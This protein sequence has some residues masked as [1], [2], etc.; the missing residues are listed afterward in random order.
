ML[1]LPRFTVSRSA[2]Q[3][4]LG[5]LFLTLALGCGSRSAQNNTV[6]KSPATAASTDHDGN[7]LK[8]G[9][10]KAFPHRFVLMPSEST[11]VD[12]EHRLSD[13][14]PEGRLYHTG[15]GCG[16]IAI[17]DI[18]GD[19]LPDLYF[20]NGPGPNRL[21]RNLGNLRFE[22]ITDAAGVDGGAT[23]S[24][25]V[26]M[27]DIDND[28]DLDLY[29]C[30]Y[31]S[32]NLL[33]IND[34]TGHFT[35]AASQW[36]LDHKDACLTATFHDYDCD[37]DLD[38]FL[39][40][41]RYYRK[42]GRPTS[43]PFVMQ[44]GKPAIKPGYAQYY[45]LNEKTPGKYSVDDYGRPNR[46][47]RNNGSSFEDI[48]EAAGI[49]GHGHTLSATWWDYNQDGWPDL[50]VC[51]DFNDPDRLYHNNGDGT[52]RDAL[53]EVVPHTPWFSMG[54]DAGDLNNDG[55]VDFFCVDMSA[56][57]HFGQKTTMGA[58]NA[59]RMA[60]VA[61]P[62]PQYM[63]NA[64]YMNTDAGRC[65]E[66]AYLAGLADSDWSWGAKLADLDNDGHMDV[67]VTNGSVRSFN[68]SDVP[69]ET[70]M[71]IGKTY[72]DLYRHLPERPEQ[73][74]VFANQ[75]DL[76]FKD[77]SQ[78]W[79]L[80]L[81]G[82]SYGAAWADLDQDNDLDL[83]VANINQPVSIYRNDV[84][85]NPGFTVRLQGETNNSFGL[86]ARVELETDKSRW[87]RY[88]NPMSGY[89][90]SNEP[91]VHFGVGDEQPRHLTV[92]WPSG[93]RQTVEVGDQRVVV[94]K[95]ADLRPISG[96]TET[97]T[98]FSQTNPLPYQHQESSFDDFE[99]Q[100]LLPNRL[101]Q[102]GPGIATAD[103]DADGDL[104]LYIG[105]S[106]RSP[107]SLMINDGQGTYRP[108]V[109]Q[110]FQDDSGYEDMGCLFF[111]ADGDDDQDLYVVSGSIESLDNMGLLIDRLYLNDGNLNF[112]RS[113][114]ST[115]PTSEFSG[116]AIS[117][118]DFDRDGDLD[119][120]I[121]GR[122]VPGRYPT[123]PGS[124]LYRNDAGRFT[125]V[126]RKHAEA[127]LNTGMVSGATWTDV[128]DDGWD[129][130]VIVGEWHPVRIF[131]NQQGTL[132]NQTV[133]SSLEQVSGWFNGVTARD[134]DGD[135]DIDL[136]VTNFGLNTKYHAS[137]AH[138]ALIYYGDFENNGR[139]R[140]VEAEYEGETLFPIRG[141]S[142]STHAMPFLGKK[143]ETYRDFALADLGELYT[144][145][146][147]N[148]SSQFA[149]TDLQTGVFLNEGNFEFR[150]EPLP[151][152]AQASPG[153]GVVVTEVNGDNHPDIYLVQNFHGPQVE[154]GNMDGGVSLLLLGQGNGQFTPVWPANS[155]L[156]VP[157]DATALIST[158]VNQ[159][160]WEDFV[161]GVN[162]GN[163]LGFVRKPDETLR[164][165]TVKLSGPVGNRTAVG[166][167]ITLNLVNG[168]TQTA[169]I[170]AGDGYL[171]QSSGQ[172]TFG[173][174]D[175]EVE[176]I[177]VEWPDGA[178]TTHP[179]ASDQPH[180]T[181]TFD[182]DAR[183]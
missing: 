120:F 176:T 27:V 81:V 48:T 155:G 10:A 125:D 147:L 47:L 77:Q 116:S 45:T 136:V 100:P 171:S 71:L 117:A 23:W 17:G 183:F 133:S 49:S 122:V 93:G 134:L 167:R 104:D 14:S 170:H 146:C 61:G 168:S 80:D 112:T 165:I 68:D 22:E 60:E 148:E 21:Y 156:M 44:N 46:F 178:T 30:N 103:I 130:L 145:D 1:H 59:E 126:T 135:Q 70:S 180:Y 65:M 37:G 162:Q 106:K 132:V 38:V 149:A 174:G 84:A 34:G 56:R 35:E 181:L 28:H 41:N 76:K 36:N 158:D 172:I 86:G 143:F 3:L 98:L 166:S 118:S 128:D 19:Q 58:M 63:R 108:L 111:D 138:P 152:L 13:N 54:S 24:T 140:I 99:L 16:G 9:S 102:L 154:T 62:P 109:T 87:I 144:Q 151:R 95:E 6:E 127:L 32:A 39:L 4:L 11:G 114:A 25:G 67:F 66:V 129:D 75:G 101:S 79:G 73:N 113:S 15:Y 74:L 64:V 12:L 121:G 40:N 57:T 33:Y 52:F 20:G 137:A 142:C 182:A 115:L 157:G 175:S 26:V 119:L 159:D 163:P 160:G 2:A 179:G 161:V 42:G 8:G 105:G 177:H 91:M 164:R 31:D 96:Q 29:V 83:I 107:G 110:A 94:V 173:L 5:A 97:Q 169:E 150:F 82:M 90:S 78:A 55:N 53:K 51:N 43:P 69:F 141:K 85:K 72:W 131:K 139:M 123:S 124:R 88:M 153:F 92:D 50:Y 7:Q 89:L 18:D